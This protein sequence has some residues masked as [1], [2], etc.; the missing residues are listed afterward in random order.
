M[1]V[2]VEPAAAANASDG[3]L[4]GDQAGPGRANVDV[5]SY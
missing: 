1:N 5:D 4:P 3:E 2:D